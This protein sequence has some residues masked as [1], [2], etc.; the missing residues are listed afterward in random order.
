MVAVAINKSML[1]RSTAHS[2]VRLSAAYPQCKD[3]GHDVFKSGKSD[4]IADNYMSKIMILMSFS[5]K[6]QYFEYSFK[7]KFLKNFESISKEISM[8]MYIYFHFLN[9]HN[10]IS[11]SSSRESCSFLSKAVGNKVCDTGSMVKLSK[12]KII[13]ILKYLH[14]NPRYNPWTPS[15]FIINLIPLNA[16]LYVVCWIS[17]CILLC[18]I[19]SCI[20]YVF[21]FK[22][23][24]KY[25]R[26]KSLLYQ[27]DEINPMR[28]IQRSLNIQIEQLV[29][30]MM[31]MIHCSLSFQWQL[32]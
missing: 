1:V 5:V 24:P 30:E 20:S 10:W 21:V 11:T 15:L 18:I 9:H 4:F 28:Q 27:Q 12:K 32:V 26:T 6:Y 22:Y 29:S 23:K 14:I 8:Y 7:N 13:P 17:P 31:K 2:A 3:I 25:L 19:N 16:L